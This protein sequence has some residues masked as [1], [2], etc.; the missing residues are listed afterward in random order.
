[1]A[2]I[3]SR[4]LIIRIYAGDWSLNHSAVFLAIAFARE[5]RFEAALFARRD[6]KGVSLHFAN[7]VFLLHFTLEATESAFERLVIAKLDFCH[8]VITCLSLTAEMFA[9]RC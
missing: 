1:M 9:L 2:S 5:G 3:R 8:L 4:R 7:N 6:I